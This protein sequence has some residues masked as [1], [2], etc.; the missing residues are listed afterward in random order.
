ML[1][2]GLGSLSLFLGASSTDSSCAPASEPEDPK[3]LA[4]LKGHEGPVQ[5]LAFSANGKM[6]GS[7]DT[8]GGS[9]R[10]WD[11]VRKKMTATLEVFNKQGDG[12]RFDYVRGVTF[13]PDGKTLA[14]FGSDGIVKLW[15]ATTGEISKTLSKIRTTPTRVA[16]SPNGKLLAFDDGAGVHVWNLTDDKDNCP[17]VRGVEGTTVLAFTLENKLLIAGIG[18]N[19]TSKT[20]SLW[21]VETG[22]KT[23]TCEGHSGAVIRVAFSPDGK[24]IASAGLD[25]TVRVWE[26]ST[27]KLLS[28]FKDHPGRICHLVFS[29]DGKVLGSGYKH[30]E[31]DGETDANPPAGSVRLYEVNTGKVLATLEGKQQPIGPLA[32]SP[33]GRILATGSANFCPD[34]DITLWSLPKRWTTDR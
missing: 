30:Q 18:Q 34:Y 7:A 10:V 27:G 24:T 31:A 26:A 33:D 12:Y 29:P 9:V 5:D 22:K 11:L 2:T 20:F 16:L 21:D 13:L 14:S 28:T 8:G 4:I 23:V 15:D 25:H 19:D 3:V 6:L 32:F 1:L 17:A